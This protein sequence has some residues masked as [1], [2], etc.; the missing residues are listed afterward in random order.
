MRRCCFPLSILRTDTHYTL[1]QSKAPDVLII[2]AGFAGAIVARELRMAGISSTVLEARD[3]IGGR[4][5]TAT[6]LGEVIELGGQYV[7][8]TQPHIWAEMTRYGAEIEEITGLSAQDYHFKVDLGGSVFKMD[9][10]KFWKM[11]EKSIEAFAATSEPAVVLQRPFD[12]LW[13]QQLAALHNLD[14]MTLRDRLEEMT[15]ESDV[16]RVALT[17]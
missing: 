10:D 4:T 11:L 15:F 6:W 14:K 3:R 12:P 8:W 9:P 7:H 17:G 5:L 13:S 1:P 16:E 2:G